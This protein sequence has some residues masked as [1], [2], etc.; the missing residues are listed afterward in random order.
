MELKTPSINPTTN[1][2][3]VFSMLLL[4]VFAAAI[5]VLFDYWAGND[6]RTVST[7]VLKKIQQ[8]NVPMTW[9]AAVSGLTLTS[10][11]FFFYNLSFL[12]IAAPAFFFRAQIKERFSRKSI[13]DEISERVIAE[14]GALADGTSASVRF[15]D[16][17]MY[18]LLAN[19]EGRTASAIRFNFTQLMFARSIGMILIVFSA[20]AAWAVGYCI[21]AVVGVTFSVW[22][23]VIFLYMVG[24]MFFDNV[25]AAGVLITRSR[26]RKA[27]KHSVL[28]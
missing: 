6:E 14:S 1:A 25:M 7:I 26:E 3:A 10:S 24:L 4:G 21:A 15:K 22:V 20:Y 13:F 18:L 9:V 27:K 12:F 17:Y 11:G 19:A 16:I 23:A 2:F 8:S 28:S 5:V